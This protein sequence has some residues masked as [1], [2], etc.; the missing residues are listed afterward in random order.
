MRVKSGYLLKSET[1]LILPLPFL[2]DTR[3][4]RVTGFFDVGNVYGPNDNIDAGGLRA[5]TGLSAI[6][7]SPL[8]ALTFS[9]ALPV[10][11]QPIDETQ[12]FQFTF[13]TSF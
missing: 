10:N 3:Q 8:G 7:L 1:Q 4:L 6:W 9:V 12:S 13:G 2:P 5:S 11:D